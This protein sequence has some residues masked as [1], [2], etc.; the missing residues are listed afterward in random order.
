MTYSHLIVA[1][2]R[3]RPVRTALIALAM[4]VAF[5]LYGMM[6]GVVSSLDDAIANLSETR[7]HVTSR[8]STAERLPLAHVSRIAAVDGVTAA[9][10]I[11]WFGGFYQDLS[12]TFALSG[13]DL[14]A[15]LPIYPE[16]T[17][18]A[19]QRDA[20]MRTRS[21][22]TLGAKI[23]TR[24]GLQIGDRLPM[25]SVV[26]TNADGSKT[27]VFDIVAI[28]NTVAGDDEVF[29][30]R[31]YFHFAYLDE[32]RL[33][34]RGTTGRFIASLEDPTRV[35]SVLRDIDAVFMNSAFETRSLNEK[36]FFAAGL[37]ELG[38]L[39]VFVNAILGAVLFTLLFM[40]GTSML[41]SVRERIPELAVLRSIGFTDRSVFALLLAESLSLSLTAGAI[42]LGLAA[43]VFPSVLTNMGFQTL[44]LPPAVYSR[45]LLIAIALGVAVTAWPAWRAQRL[46]IVDAL[47]RR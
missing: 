16:I 39:N 46:P 17:L 20:L 33:E 47:T 12:Q 36:Q 45:G 1:G 32:A 13:T 8:A 18:S 44:P 29:A 11:D 5:L 24:Y 25:Q 27:W 7:V 34:E 19:D 9:M 21:G 6:H 42:G 28:H 3:R 15:F 2:L 41:Q 43:W 38:S 14:E 4:I 23:A 22:V 31:A 37:R 26:W 10:P 30:D 35:D 40:T